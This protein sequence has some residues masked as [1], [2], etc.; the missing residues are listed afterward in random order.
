[1]KIITSIKHTE[2]TTLF[3]LLNVLVKTIKENWA[4]K[5]LYF[6][7]NTAV[8]FHYDNLPQNM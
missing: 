5:S 4:I 8:K 3:T 2:S 6:M 1:M 7:Y